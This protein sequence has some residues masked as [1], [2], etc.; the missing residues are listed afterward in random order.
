VGFSLPKR[1]RPFLPH[2]PTLTSAVLRVLLRAIRTLLLKNSPGAPEDGRIGAI[3]FPHRFG[4][5]LN[6]HFH[7]HIVVLDGL[8]SEDAH[9]ARS[10][11]RKLLWRH[12]TRLSNVSLFRPMR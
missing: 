2:N 10:E 9:Q 4:S 12:Y 8:F 5:S 6:A 3:S 7:F 11:R 1:L